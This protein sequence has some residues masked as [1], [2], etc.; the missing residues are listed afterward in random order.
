MT[1]EPCLGRGW[2]A[3]PTRTAVPCP[4][5]NGRGELSWWALA[6]KLGEQPAT[7]ARIRQGRS[8]VKT[9]M[10]VLEKV[11]KLLW[12]KQKELFT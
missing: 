2:V 12:P 10:R 4:I 3:H 8:K 5:C 7:L 1:W 9:C 6:K 11:Q